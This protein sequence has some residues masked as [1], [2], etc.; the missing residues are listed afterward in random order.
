[1]LQYPS[2]DSNLS[3]N[4]KRYSELSVPATAGSLGNNSILFDGMYYN[5][6]ISFSEYAGNWPCNI[7]YTYNSGNLFDVS[8][9]LDMPE[10]GQFPIYTVNNFT[11]ITTGGL[12]ASG[13]PTPYWI[14]TNIS[15]SDTV[16]INNDQFQVNAITRIEYK[17]AEYEC[18]ELICVNSYTNSSAY[19][20][21][22][23]GVLIKGYFETESGF[24]YHTISLEATNAPVKPVPISISAPQNTT[25]YYSEVPIIVQNNTVF[26]EMWYRNSTD[27]GNTWS[28]NS[29]LAFDGT[30]FSNTTVLNWT[31]GEYYLQVFG[32]D[33]T[34][35]EF[36]YSV[37][38][39]INKFGP[40]IDILTPTNSTYS[41]Y[42]ITNNQ[43][44]ISV[45]NHTYAH[46]AWFRYNSGGSWTDNA[47][48]TW[49]DA[50]F[51]NIIPSIPFGDI[52]LQ[53][54]ANDSFNQISS[55]ALWFHFQQLKLPQNYSS[56]LTT[57]TWIDATTGIR[58]GMENVDD[59]AERY[60]FPFTFNFYNESFT[61]FYVCTNGFISFSY[62]NDW[63]T[64]PFPTAQFPLMIAPLWDDL[65]SSSPSNIYVLNLTAPNRVVVEWKDIDYSS[66]GF[67][68]GSFECI[69][70][71]S[72]EIIFNY[73]Y[74]DFVSSYSSFGLNLGLDT[75]FF[76][77]SINLNSATDDLALSFSYAPNDFAPT[78]GD[79]R[80]SAISGNQATP[81]NFTVTYADSD[82][83]APSFIRMII[84]GTPFQM[85][86]ID[87][88]DT[89]YTDGCN[90]SVVT[91]L[92]AEGTYSYYFECS[93]NVYITTL[94]GE[95][96][97]SVVFTN[98][99]SPSL[100]GGTVT[101]S[102]GLAG[103]TIFRFKVTYADQDNNPPLYVNV[104]INGQVHAMS[105]EDAGDLN[106]V[107]GCNYY[108]ETDVPAGSNTYFFN[109]SDGLYQTGTSIFSGPI[110]EILTEF[111][112]IINEFNT[113]YGWVELHN[114]TNS[115][116]NLT[117][118]QINIYQGTTNIDNYTFPAFLLQP[119]GFVV[120]H[121]QTGTDNATALFTGFLFSWAGSGK[122][123]V[124]L[125]HKSGFCVDYVEWNSYA[126][127]QP[128]DA[129]W[130]GDIIV[131]IAM[132]HGAFYRH[133]LQD[134]NSSSDWSTDLPAAGTPY[135]L[136]PGQNIAPHL[137][138]GTVTPTTGKSTT[139]FR[140]TVTYK[141]TENQA[142]LGYIRVYID[143]ICYNMLEENPTSQDYAAGKVY[144]YETTLPIGTHQYYFNSTDGYELVTTSVANLVV[145]D[146]SGDG[147]EG[148]LIWIIV[149]VIGGAGVAILGIALYIRKKK[150][151]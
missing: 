27:G 127:P 61:S 38:F 45:Q 98:S 46:S 115:L 120:I 36:S 113:F 102:E 128:P 31:N 138:G 143:G 151:M 56:S 84:N 103:F 133:T 58:S 139:K 129:Q 91:Y 101:P 30:H 80:V 97:I 147:G 66:S 67:L 60:Q 81:F 92:S 94:L 26:D 1:M 19:Y 25:Y 17:D 99:Y 57:Y 37:N 2:I 74:L 13:T 131:T 68:V 18:F 86:K 87:S 51:T 108:F 10:G 95:T 76:N 23:T 34:S 62:C 22:N 121:Q 64:E 96:T 144:Y 49:D 47:S 89:T 93:D 52:Y 59:G 7:S 43:I 71:E 39:T 132:Q 8:E 107:D 28:G 106:Y 32:N 21:V 126:G 130:S 134:T 65:E 50:I 70:Y 123:A 24:S 142:P 33:S 16:Q 90:Y 110:S 79:G 122:G 73:D 11:R 53:V 40:W 119:R 3:K 85:Q 88:L 135:V 83:N 15:I 141:D 78:L 29:S 125:I 114:P 77:Q 116:I 148:N 140:F 6:S 44:M 41:S 12:W 105:K 20:D 112:I 9:Y 150:R 145:N 82:N 42:N 69:L 137:E 72:G 54:F 117:N 146:S 48:L 111:R 35:N 109:C 5:S 149:G 4:V 118:W 55:R 136:D 124:G 100:S 104:T 63:E 75:R 14:L